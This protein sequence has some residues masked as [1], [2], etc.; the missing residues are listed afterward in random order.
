MAPKGPASLQPA[1]YSADEV[2]ELTEL[3]DL[4]R[5]AYLCLVKQQQ[6]LV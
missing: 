1:S 6:A 4:G 3:G 2:G 5:E